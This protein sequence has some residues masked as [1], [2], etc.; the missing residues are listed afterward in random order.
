M[1]SVLLLY[2]IAICHMIPTSQYFEL[3]APIAT[4]LYDNIPIGRLC[5]NCKYDERMICTTGKNPCLP[6]Q[7][8]TQSANHCSEAAVP[9]SLSFS[10]T[11]HWSPVT[12]HIFFTAA[13]QPARPHPAGPSDSQNAMRWKYPVQEARLWCI[14]R[15]ESGGAAASSPSE[16]VDSSWPPAIRQ[17]LRGAPSSAAS[18]RCSWSSRPFAWPTSSD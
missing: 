9:S 7:S 18:L 12:D 10:S 16:G 14:V 11:G 1:S 2:F 4:L 8:I 13:K 5:A 15:P 3:A 6:N 17:H